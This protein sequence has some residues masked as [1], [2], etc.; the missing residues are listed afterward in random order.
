MKKRGSRKLHLSRET[1]RV[2]ALGP[3]DLKQ[4]VGGTDS[5]DLRC[6]HLLTCTIPTETVVTAHV[7]GV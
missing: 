7:D 2:L 3:K 1:L 4:A 6:T 5:D